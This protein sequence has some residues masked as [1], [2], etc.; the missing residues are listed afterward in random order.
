MA[1]CSRSAR[2]QRT[3]RRCS[4]TTSRRS[5]FWS[6]TSIRSRRR[7]GE[8]RSFDDRIE[9]IDIGGPAMIR[10]AAK[11]HDDVVV[12]VDADDYPALIDELRRERGGDQPRLPPD[13]GAEG[14]RP[15]R[16]LRRG[17][18][19]L[20]GAARSMSRRRTGAPSA[21]STASARCATARI[22][23]SAPRFY[24]DRRDPPGRR[25]RSSGSGQ[26]ALLQQHQRHRRSL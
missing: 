2:S 10:A 16:R 11:N 20:A 18:L 19:Q 3:R 15:N 25:D 4:P 6:S 14:L 24:L 22:R 8:A 12:I 26:G 13:D 21:A 23:I 7:C 17:D 5:I 9:N 1:A